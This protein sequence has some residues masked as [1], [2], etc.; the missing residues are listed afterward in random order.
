VLDRETFAKFPW[1]GSTRP[2]ADDP[3]ELV[4]NRTWRPQLAVIGADGLPA[5]GDAGNVLLPFT[6]LKLSLR[7]PP[8]LEAG[9]A[10]RALKRILTEDPPAGAEIGYVPGNS[11][12]GWNAP[13]LAQWLDESLSR[14]GQTVFGAPHVQMGEGG[15]IP[16]MGMLGEKFPHTQFVI[17]GVLGPGSNAHGP[18]EFLHIPTAKRI[19]QVIALVIADHLN[20]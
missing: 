19:S 6:V 11:M 5:P 1:A 15:S 18:N 3:T 7:L 20:R 9:K 8:T 13:P 4:L 10:E 2:M 14:A 17:T 12:R 16:F